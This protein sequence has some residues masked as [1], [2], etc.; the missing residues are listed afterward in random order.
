MNNLNDKL[1]SI[2]KDYYK[3]MEI[4]QINNFYKYLESIDNSIVIN[5]MSIQNEIFQNFNAMRGRFGV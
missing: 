5:Y 4:K 1:T 3:N 2:Y